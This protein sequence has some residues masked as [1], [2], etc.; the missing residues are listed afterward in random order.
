MAKT[1]GLAQ[2]EISVEKTKNIVIN[3]KDNTYV[4]INVLSGQVEEVNHFE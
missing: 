1:L 2:L 3:T 4:P